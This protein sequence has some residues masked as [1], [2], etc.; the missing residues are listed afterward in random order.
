MT[1][2]RPELFVATIG[3][4]TKTDTGV[5]THVNAF[6]SYAAARNEAVRLLTPFN[7]T[8]LLV[9]PVFGAGRLLKLIGSAPWVWWYRLGHYVLLRLDTTRTLRPGTPAVVYAQDLL[10]AKAALDARDAGYA[11][12]V[13]LNVH[14]YTAPAEEW[15]AN[16]YIRRGGRIFR[17]IER[18]EEQTIPRVDRLLFPSE[19]MARNVMRRVAGAARVPSWRIPNF[20]IRNDA[21]A[22]PGGE[23]GELISIGPLVPNKNHEF[24][25]RVLAHAHRMGR[26][27][28]LLIVGNG[29]LRKRLE[30]TAAELGV[31]GYVAFAGFVPDA[32]RLI[33][34]HRLYVHAAHLENCCIAVLEALAAGKPVLAAPR[35]GIPEQFTNGVEGFYWEPGD[36][37]GAARLLVRL[38]DDRVLYQHMSHAAR[39]R[40]ET[41]FAP[42]VVAP[43]VW[44]A[45]L[46]SSAE[47]PRIESQNAYA[48][49]PHRA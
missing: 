20:V 47:A 7:V 49:Q 19:Y 12:D 2:K 18:L 13:V 44:R 41:Q 30:A 28:R 43:R 10:S 33:P 6:M 40:F 8:P 14:S 38:L 17:Q 48:A 36:P 11:V 27:C 16:G 3:R 42:E 21:R 5:Q 22:A 26:R 46:G 4:P 1:E 45:V 31:G 25:I 15:V 24:L 37:E 29:P 23:S 9:Y 35:G 32:A 39:A 34:H